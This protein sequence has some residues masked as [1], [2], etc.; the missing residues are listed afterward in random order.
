MT[1][2]KLITNQNP[3]QSSPESELNA[4]SLRSQFRLINFQS[5]KVAV[6]K[7]AHDFITNQDNMSVEKINA[8]ME[9][10]RRIA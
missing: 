7:E 4:Q 9:K 5:E 6:M 8:M 3:V 10:I 2:L 1:N